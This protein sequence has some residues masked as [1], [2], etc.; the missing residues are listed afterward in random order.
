MPG[1]LRHGIYSRTFTEEGN[2]APQLAHAVSDQSSPEDQAWSFQVPANTFSDA[3]GDALTYSASLGDGSA[4]PSWLT[5]NAATRTFSGTPTDA[6]VGTLS[7][8]VTATDHS[9]ASVSDTF[10]LAVSSNNRAPVITLDGGGDSA[11]IAMAENSVLAATVT[12]SDPDGD[13]LVYSIMGGADAAL[14]SIDAAGGA[15]SFITPPNYEAPADS[16]GDNIYRVIVQVSDGRAS[17]TQAIAITV[18]N[19]AGPT[20]TGTSSGEFI[21]GTAEEETILG[22]GGA[23][24]LYGDAGNDTLDGGVGNDTLIGGSGDDHMIG[25]RG[26]DLFIVDSLLD[27]IVEKL[28]EGTDTAETA[29]SAYSL[30]GI[31]NIENLTF[32]GS[33][34]FHGTGNAL[35]NTIRGGTGNDTLDGGAGKDTLVGGS[36]DDTYL[37]DTSSDVITEVTNGGTDT[38]LSTANSYGLANN[39]ENLVFVGTGAFTGTGNTLSNAITGGS[40]ADTLSG[41]A[42]QDTLDGGAGNDRLIGG[43]DADLLTGGLGLDTFVYAS[44]TDS[45]ASALDTIRAFNPADDQF[46][47]RGLK[48]T[49][50]SNDVLNKGSGGLL[51]SNVTDFFK[52]GGTK[53]DVAYLTDGAN[54]YVYADANGDGS[55]RPTQD[56]VIKLADFTGPL[57]DLDFFL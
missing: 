43:A 56:L 21:N 15:L 44:P 55:F 57:T 35:D 18:T 42:G 48:L 11:S 3:D 52:L 23:D 46:D 51:T 45:K 49:D 8:K 53:Y 47:F 25:G 22:L 31:A 5:F 13:S 2:H 34:P 7:V 16:D 26:N 37:V 1:R 29:L 27:T 28:G 50:S 33:G 40:G 24:T 19:I 9:G 14:F 20:I 30:A 41:G 12:A 36:G 54:T 32:T 38:V 10:E 17:D 39:V 4:L 6:D